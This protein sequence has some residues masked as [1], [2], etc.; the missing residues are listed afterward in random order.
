MN[1]EIITFGCRLNQYESEVIQN[2]LDKTNLQNVIVFNT[3]AV[4]KEAER[5]ARQKIRSAKKQ[6]PDKK[7][8]VL[9]CG[10]QVSSEVFA[11]M[12][13]VDIV[14]GNKGKLS[15]DQYYEISDILSSESNTSSFYDKI[16]KHSLDQDIDQREWIDDDFQIGKFRNKTRAI[17]QV[18]NGCNHQCTFCITWKARGKSRSVPPELVIKRIQSI[19]D[20]GYKEVVLTGIDTSD[21]GK[22]LEFKMT[23]GELCDGILN[24]VNGLKRLR[25]S[26]IDVA[27]FDDTLYE[28]Y[29][30]HDRFMPHFHISLQ[31]GDDYVLQKMM[32]RHRSKDI[33]S[34]AENIRKIK[35]ETHLGG[36][37]IA[38]F[39]GETMEMFTN[40]CNVLKEANIFLNHIFTY[41]ERPDT[42]AAS[43]K[44]LPTEE[45]KRRCKEL[46]EF[47]NE[48]K[49]NSLAKMIGQEV[50]I[51]IENDLR[52]KTENFI[53][54]EFL[55][56]ENLQP[57]S[58]IQTTI[59]DSAK[60]YLI[61]G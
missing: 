57:G 9:G 43:M 42:I 8:I 6:N 35:P 20:G 15:I 16:I 30:K 25:L 18:Q 34:F 60:T 47:S 27:E 14:L 33:L 44:Q 31:S 48:L 36:D 32:R 1:N 37:L 3:C 17:V 11:R 51:L 41:S 46:I 10:S 23:L 45:R 26:S 2:I 13:E 7:I 55:T 5:Q 50:K 39:P 49:A 24:R 40:T 54:V 38:G 61:G 12:N 53:D 21:Y 4:T 28:A 29:A 19:V 52:G 22:D 58:I 59:I 56:N